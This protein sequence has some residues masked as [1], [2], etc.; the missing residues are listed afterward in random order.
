MGL[1]YIPNIMRRIQK[2]RELKE[3]QARSWPHADGMEFP[4]FHPIGSQFQGN[5]ALLYPITARKNGINPISPK[6]SKGQLERIFPLIY[7]AEGWNDGT[8]AGAGDEHPA[9]RIL[10]PGAVL[11]AL[12]AYP[13]GLIRAAMARIEAGRVIGQSQGGAGGRA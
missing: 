12:L 5:K 8:K 6:L 2:Y 9:E 7:C 1:V 13:L 4:R 11:L 3:L 10:S